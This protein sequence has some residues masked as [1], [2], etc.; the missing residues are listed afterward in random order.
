MLN[1]SNHAQ[2]KANYENYMRKFQSDKI[3]QLNDGGNSFLAEIDE[4]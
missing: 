3:I 4:E 1:E 2:K